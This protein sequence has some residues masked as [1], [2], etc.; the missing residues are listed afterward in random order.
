M[1]SI[2]CIGRL[3]CKLFYGRRERM[4]CPATSIWVPFCWKIGRGVHFIDFFT[5]VL[6]KT[7]LPLFLDSKLLR[8]MSI[9]SL[10][11]FLRSTGLR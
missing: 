5:Q 8:L 7:P 2:N 3:A 1:H 9:Q 10:I 6:A 11:A 4:C